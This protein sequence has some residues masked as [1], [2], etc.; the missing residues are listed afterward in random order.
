MKNHSKAQSSMGL[1]ILFISALFVAAIGAGVFI[2]SNNEFQAKATITGDQT[3]KDVSSAFFT[4][5]IT[6][7]DGRTGGVDIFRHIVKIPPGM[8]AIDLE[9]VTLVFSTENMTATLLYK[10]VGSTTNHGSAA[11]RFQSPT[12]GQQARSSSRSSELRALK[13]SPARSCLSAR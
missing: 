1:L 4:M 7:T 5:D 12:H 10:G 9:F 3:R 11:S 8:E 6:A 13:I 2:T